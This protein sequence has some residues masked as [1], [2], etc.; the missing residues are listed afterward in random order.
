VLP[1]SLSGSRYVGD[2]FFQLNEFVLFAKDSEIIKVL[3][4]VTEFNKDI[5]LLSTP[6]L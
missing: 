4:K 3:L 6:T 5:K 1:A 2:L